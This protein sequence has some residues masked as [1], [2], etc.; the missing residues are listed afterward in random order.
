MEHSSNPAGRLYLFFS[1]VL[2][3]E[4]TAASN[5]DNLLRLVQDYTRGS[6]GE[7]VHQPI[8]GAPYLYEAVAALWRL[9]DQASDQIT[10]LAE[11]VLP[12]S[13]LMRPLPRAKKL[14]N[15][16]EHL[17]SHKSKIKDGISEDFL[18]DL[19][20]TSHLLGKSPILQLSDEM[21]LESIQQLTA[22][23]RVLLLESDLSAEYKDLVETYINGI[24]WASTNVRL[25]GTKGLVAERDRMVGM[26]L[27]RG[28]IVSAMQEDQKLSERIWE[29]LN[30]IAVVVSITTVP[31]SIAADTAGLLAIATGQPQ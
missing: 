14:L 3:K 29:L 5:A 15:E 19:E 22:E 2:T 28:D 6:G 27:R 30:K 16:F 20:V 31:L 23:I 26:L 4:L 24:A 8:G 17:T 18:N 9:P 7:F 13:V 10:Q 25:Y 21:A 1:F 11:P 12:K